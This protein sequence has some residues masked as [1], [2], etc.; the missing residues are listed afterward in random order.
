MKV[1]FYITEE[2]RRALEALFSEAHD[3]EY[4]ST[5][6]FCD[7]RR[8]TGKPV[9][10]VYKQIYED[11]LDIF[12]QPGEDFLWRTVTDNVLSVK[13]LKATFNGRRASL[14]YSDVLG[15][16]VNEVLRHVVGRGDWRYLASQRTD[17]GPLEECQ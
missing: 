2:E 10:L 14:L 16:A 11:W 13:K 3:E 1:E 6:S 12:G 17:I 5:S 15:A 9:G 7:P 4:S 8:L